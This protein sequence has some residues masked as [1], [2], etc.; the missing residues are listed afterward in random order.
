M[1]ILAVSL[2]RCVQDGDA[3]LCAKRMA[4]LHYIMQLVCIRCVY[5][6]L[7]AQFVVIQTNCELQTHDGGV[8]SRVLE[9]L[10]QYS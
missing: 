1:T 8:N 3:R 7:V 10:S 9:I 6:F 2:V 5:I 4:L